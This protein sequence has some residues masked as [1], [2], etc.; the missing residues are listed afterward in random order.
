MGSW[1]SPHDPE[2][3]RRSIRWHGAGS[4]GAGKSHGASC[5]IASLRPTSRRTPCSRRGS[6]SA[7]WSSRHRDLVWAAA[8]ALGERDASL[9]DLHLRHGLEPHELAD[10]LDIAPNA[11]HQSLFR[12]RKRLGGAI[13][14]QL[15]WRDGEPACVA[16][17]AELAAAGIETF[18]AATVRLIERH[19][20]DC[21]TCAEERARVVAPA[22]LFSAVPM[23]PPPDGLRENALRMLANEG[24]PTGHADNPPQPPRGDGAGPALARRKVAAWAGAVLVVAALFGGLVLWRG[25]AGGPE[26][27]AQPAPTTQSSPTTTKPTSPPVTSTAQPRPEQ[28]PPARPRLTELGATP[29]ELWE[30][31]KPCAERPTTSRVSVRI[32]DSATLPTVELR[33]SAGDNEGAQDLI[34]ARWRMSSCSLGRKLP[35]RSVVA[36]EALNGDRGRE[37]PDGPVDAARPQ[38]AQRSRPCSRTCVRRA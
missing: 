11:A 32:A 10:E 18:S 34:S 33:W 26:P 13:R 9:L 29:D 19:A 25:D 38:A 21:A 31:G 28:P 17:R 3:P 20:K 22:A 12:L 14:A 30:K 37:V 35:I 15:L 24:V 8:A 27:A 23:V 5:T 2:T 4:I 6:S 1:S 16:L 7:G 36:G